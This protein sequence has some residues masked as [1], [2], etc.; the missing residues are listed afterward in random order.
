[1]KLRNFWQILFATTMSLTMAACVS[2]RISQ[3]E[4]NDIGASVASSMKFYIAVEKTQA[5]A[6]ERRQNADIWSWQKEESVYE[7]REATLKHIVA[8][9]HETSEWDAIPNLQKNFDAGE[10]WSAIKDA[11]PAASKHFT[12][13]AAVE[14]V[15]WTID[16]LAKEYTRLNRVEF[17]LPEFVSKT[18]NREVFK[19]YCTYND[20]YYKIVR[21]S[22]GGY[23]WDFSDIFI[24]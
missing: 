8:Y 12:N 17:K 24:D 19:S 11:I 7:V 10:V 18:K 15:K 4:W 2:P 1:M 20:T 13:A 23:L 16:N 21:T 3:E 9:F 6:Q 22:D 14:H 5:Q